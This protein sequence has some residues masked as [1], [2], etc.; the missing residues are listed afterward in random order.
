VPAAGPRRGMSSAQ[1]NGAAIPEELPESGLCGYDKGAFTGANQSKRGR[2]QYADGGTLFL[3]EI[4]DMKPSLQAKLLRVLQEKEFEP[5]G[6]VKPV[7]VDV[8]IIAATHRNLE[9]AVEEGTFREDLFYRLSVFPL[10]IPPL[11]E[12]KEDI[13]LL[14]DKFVQVFNRKKPRP[15]LGFEQGAIEA[16]LEHSWPG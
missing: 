4:G 1:A 6:A 3:D 2:V 7:S 8:R 13:P 10:H 15:F 12:R 16:L 11:R 9:R 14:I 5:L